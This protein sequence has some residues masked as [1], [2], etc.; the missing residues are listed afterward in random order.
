MTGADKRMNAP[1]FGS[2]LTESRSRSGS[3]SRLFSKSGFKSQI[4]F[5]L[6]EILVLAEVCTPEYS[7]VRK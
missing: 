4:I 1:Q 3:R 5:G 7:L 2:D 6:V